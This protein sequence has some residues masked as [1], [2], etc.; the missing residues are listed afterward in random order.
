MPLR[1]S[2]NRKSRSRCKYGR[3]KSARQGCKKRPGPKRKSTRRV[4]R[5][6]V[7][8]S[9]NPVRRS[10]KP[11][12]RSRKPVRRSRKP[13]RR[14]RKPVRRSRKPVRRSR[15][16]VRRSR[17]P[18]R[19][20]RKPVRRSR[21]PV[22]RSRKSKQYVKGITNAELRKYGLGPNRWYYKYRMNQNQAQTLFQK[23][24]K[25]NQST[26]LKKK[27]YE[28][29][30][31]NHPDKG[32]NNE[33]FKLLSNAYNVLKNEQDDND[34]KK[35]DKDMTI[36]DSKG[37]Q[38]T[39]KPRD[40][41]S[42]YVNTSRREA[43]ARWQAQARKKAE[44]RREAEEIARREAELRRQAEEVARR[45]A[46]TRRQA[47]AEARRQAEAEARRKVRLPVID[48]R[49][50]MVFEPSSQTS[51]YQSHDDQT[52]QWMDPVMIPGHYPEG[53]NY[54]SVRYHLKNDRRIDADR[55][56]LQS[57]TK[58][59]TLMQAKTPANFITI[60]NRFGRELSEASGWFSG[61]KKRMLR[62]YLKEATDRV[63]P[64]NHK[65][66]TAIDLVE[67][68]D[69]SGRPPPSLSYLIDDAL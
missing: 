69:L 19:R 56:P 14:S 46:E 11:V 13:V 49:W 3:K 66:R 16:P 65:E 61:R 10:R 64:L 4:S 23:L 60:V 24:W 20:S 32:G 53:A 55:V 15:K 35:L 47:E 42:Y 43:E 2:Q 62:K 44:A 30:K 27:F 68:A 9:R 21:K 18:V 58:K 48:G 28:L 45:Q 31:K 7:R 50:E 67:I 34:Y 22:R 57:L 26:G 29:S 54:D 33:A 52:T 41:E 40:W 6:P 59:N 37:T 63:P 51:Y 36:K 12:R 1:K 25:G 38:I 39:I 8:R 17:K 5:K